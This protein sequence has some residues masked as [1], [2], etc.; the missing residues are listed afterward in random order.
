MNKEQQIQA[1]WKHIKGKIK[2]KWGK[3]TDEE[4]EKIN[5]R[6]EQL[7]G[8]IQ[9]KYGLSKERAEMQLDEFLNTLHL[10]ES[11]PET[12]HQSRR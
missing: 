1:H 8:K 4:M 3:L 12:R 11:M 6:R 7:I 10:E 9:A 5:G 2:E